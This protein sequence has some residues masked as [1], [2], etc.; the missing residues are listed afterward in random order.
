[1][2]EHY[3]QYIQLNGCAILRAEKNW[4]LDGNVEIEI[5]SDFGYTDSGQYGKIIRYNALLKWI[6]GSDISPYIPIIAN[7]QGK[8][9]LEAL[10]NLEEQ[11]K[12]M[13]SEDPNYFHIGLKQ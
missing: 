6:Y 2:L 12:T 5:C 1:M 13:L 8:T 4:T 7:G 9:V 3:I 11:L 10:A